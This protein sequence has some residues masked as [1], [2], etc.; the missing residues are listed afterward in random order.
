MPIA[1]AVAMFFVA[2][3]FITVLSALLLGEPIGPR[4]I[5]AVLVGFAGVVITVRIRPE[6]SSTPT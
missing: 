2:P 5:A 3:L 4:R 6:P 1:E